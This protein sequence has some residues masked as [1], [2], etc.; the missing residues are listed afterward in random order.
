MRKYFYCLLLCSILF[1]TCDKG[2]VLDTSSNTAID[3]IAD[4]TFLGE[5][6]YT[7][8]FDNSMK[9]GP[10]ICL[11][12]ISRNGTLFEDKYDLNM[13]GQGYFAI[14]NDG[15]NLYLQSQNFNSILKCSTIGEIFYHKW[16]AG[17]L[18]GKACGIAYDSKS[19]SLLALYK[20][21]KEDMQYALY[22]FNKNN[23]TQWHLKG[24][25]KIQELNHE[26]GAY[27]IDIKDNS[28]F[29]LGQDTTNTD[30]IIKT[31]FALNILEYTG[32]NTNS[33]TRFCFK[34]GEAFFGFLDKFIKKIDF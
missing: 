34:E 15:S 4:I 17:G 21:P 10:Q 9:A 33:T 8:N 26:I 14:T 11:Y 23:P 20:R 2:K 13:N 3:P 1:F 19:D 12:K 28:L 25:N 29:I 27:A 7:T 5:Y 24:S 32:L 16:F 18:E 22:M 6:F 30:V 31:D